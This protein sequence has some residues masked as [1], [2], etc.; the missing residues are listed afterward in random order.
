MSKKNE[1]NE[2]LLSAAASFFEKAL[3]KLPSPHR[4]SLVFLFTILLGMLIQDGSSFR[5]YGL[6]LLFGVGVT[7]LILSFASQIYKTKLHY[8]Q[9]TEKAFKEALRNEVLDR[10]KEM[11]LL[12]TIYRFFS[13]EQELRELFSRFQITYTSCTIDYDSLG[14]DDHDKLAKVCDLVLYCQRHN[15]TDELIQT[16]RVLRPTASI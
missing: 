16:I 3:D 11:K 5:M 2:G 6:L 10:Q 7:S 13:N 15:A 4:L 9:R 1:I 8:F 14:A 12:E